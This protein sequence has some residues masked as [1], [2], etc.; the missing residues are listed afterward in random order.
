[1]LESLL[2]AQGWSEDD[3]DDAALIITEV[4]QNAVEHGSLGDGSETIRIQVHAQSE[5]VDMVVE[6]PGTGE[7]PRLAVERDVA[8]PVP[9]DA[10]R[11]RGLYLIYRLSQRFDRSLT[12]AGGLR[13]RA[14]KE[15]GTS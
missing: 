6:D 7:E 12:T 15:I 3:V 5:A 2:D 8:L 1:M 10:P 14:R 9:L 13:V 4:V 11:G